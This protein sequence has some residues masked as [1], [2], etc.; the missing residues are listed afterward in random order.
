ELWLLN[1]LPVPI[2]TLPWMLLRQGLQ[3]F[4]AA[5]EAVSSMRN[6][7]QPFFQEKGVLV[8]QLGEY[9]INTNQLFEMLF[10]LG[11]IK[12]SYGATLLMFFNVIRRD[13][14]ADEIMSLAP[15][16]EDVTERYPMQLTPSPDDDSSIRQ[17]KQYLR[18]I[19]LAWVLNVRVLLDV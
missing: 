11:H 3:E 1:Q 14:N 13:M 15:S 19:Y 9:I 4:K 10:L 5:G 16:P 12:P 17:F 8:R 18:A 7:G 2:E 6:E